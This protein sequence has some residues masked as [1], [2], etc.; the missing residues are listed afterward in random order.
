[1]VLQRD[2]TSE[3]RAIFER[4]KVDASLMMQ[5]GGTSTKAST[6]SPAHSGCSRSVSNAISVFHSKATQ[7][8]RSLSHTSESIAHLTQ[9]I[10]QQTV[11]DDGAPEIAS[12]MSIVKKQLGDLHDELGT[13]TECKQEAISGAGSSNALQADKHGDVVIATL[14]SRLVQTS[15]D[16]KTLLQERTK[17][18]KETCARRNQFSS[19]KPTTFES[20]LFQ[21][22]ADG[23]S[24]AAPLVGE[25]VD[26]Q[27]ADLAL[28]PPVHYFRQRLDAVRQL[29]AAV[30]EVGELFNDF[31]RLVHEQ[32]EMVVRIDNDVDD[33]L[34]NVNAG[35]SE[36]LKYLASVSSNRGLIL[37]IFFVLFVFLLFFGLIVVR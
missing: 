3:F 10:K 30:T 13:L 16:F 26:G 17:T 21:Q 33:A 29:E 8:S 34:K 19:D 35:S 23:S 12:L 31:T 36:L 27:R 37:K 22:A 28:A 7:F 32:E 4:K 5:Q 1:M 9:L 6:A 25:N 24:E 20:A 2:R 15:N 18:M 14:R 11:F